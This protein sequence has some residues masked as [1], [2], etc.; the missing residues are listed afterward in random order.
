MATA[1]V[2]VPSGLLAGPNWCRTG[3]DDREVQQW[4]T[5]SLITLRRS[6]GSLWEPAR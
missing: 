2:C 1:S 3:V 6:D 5:C 4:I